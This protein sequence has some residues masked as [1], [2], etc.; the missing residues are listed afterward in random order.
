M[1][2]RIF[3]KRL[4]LTALGGSAAGILL[5]RLVIKP[6][7][8]MAGDPPWLR[9]AIAVTLLGV[10]VGMFALLLFAR[11]AAGRRRRLRQI[12]SGK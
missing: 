1:N 4:W 2:K 12:H 9:T 7:M 6:L 5:S 8:H 11:L 3:T 10:L